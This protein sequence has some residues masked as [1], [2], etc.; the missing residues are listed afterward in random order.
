M[1]QS[2]KAL[3]GLILVLTNLKRMSDEKGKLIKMV[4]LQLSFET[5]FQ[6]AKKKIGTFHSA[7]LKVGQNFP[8]MLIKESR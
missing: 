6:W 1:V 2:C 8:S 7:F 4:E 5:E 3:F